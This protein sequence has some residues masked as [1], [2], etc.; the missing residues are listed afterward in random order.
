MVA[1]GYNPV[2]RPSGGMADAVVS[3]TSVQKTCEF[4][5]HLGHHSKGKDSQ[6][7]ESF[8]FCATA[9]GRGNL[10]SGT[11][12][13]EKTPSNGGLSYLLLGNKAVNR[14][15]NYCNCIKIPFV[16]RLALTSR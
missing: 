12:Q 4:E 5:S 9:G 16:F 7:W 13:H 15:K 6:Q 8:V 2:L 10:T 14:T 3:K 1:F 11:T